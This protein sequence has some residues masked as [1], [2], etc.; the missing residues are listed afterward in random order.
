MPGSTAGGLDERGREGDPRSRCDLDGGEPARRYEDPALAYDR[1]C[2]VHG[3]RPR[4]V[5]QGGVRRLLARG[6][7]CDHRG[8]GRNQGNRGDG[9]LGLSPQPAHGYGHPGGRRADAEAFGLYPVDP[10]QGERRALAAHAG[11]ESAR[12]QRVALTQ[13][14]RL[15]DDCGCARL[16]CNPNEVPMTIVIYKIVKHENGWAYQA[17]GTFSETFATHDA[18]LAAARIAAAEQKV[19]G[20]T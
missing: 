7:R 8:G 18:A 1:R 11:R 5:R 10:A 12:G 6:D 9:E 14:E 2:D 15:A 20:E 17:R 19:P 16:R 3:P 13:V 4:A